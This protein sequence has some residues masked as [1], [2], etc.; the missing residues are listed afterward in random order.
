MSALGDG[1]RSATMT[2]AVALVAVLLV[3]GCGSRAGSPDSASGPTPTDAAGVQGGDDGQ[4]AAGEGDGATTTAAPPPDAT[5][6]TV[7]VAGGPGGAAGAGGSTGTTTPKPPM[8]IKVTFASKCVV[9]GTAQ[10]MTIDLGEPGALLYAKNR[11]GT[12]ESH[13]A[14]TGKH[15]AQ[16][17][18]PPDTPPG[19]ATVNVSAASY[20]GARG[21]TKATFTVAGVG[22]SC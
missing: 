22:G 3:A 11:F 6:P 10:A 15:Q 8:N 13:H 21:E 4:G 18:V 1:R 16:W 2:G 12:S 14:P 19:A 9:A 17:V 7:A 5:Q 20:T